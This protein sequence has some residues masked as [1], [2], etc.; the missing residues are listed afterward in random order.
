M[1]QS[2]HR[3]RD[4]W[5]GR[6]RERERE[7]ERERARERESERKGESERRTFGVQVVHG[8]D[9]L[10]HVLLDHQGIQIGLSMSDVL[11]DVLVQQLEHER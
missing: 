2:G 1:E 8:F 7:R 3:E 10:I 9:Q 6:G 11:V 5:R 4:R